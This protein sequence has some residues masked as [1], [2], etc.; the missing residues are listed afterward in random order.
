MGN[1]KLKY[2]YSSEYITPMMC[3]K[4][5][6]GPRVRALCIAIQVG[7]AIPD[8]RLTI[9]GSQAASAC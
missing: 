3:V 9:I 1:G 5:F 2:I 8:A 4:T 7:K 6:L